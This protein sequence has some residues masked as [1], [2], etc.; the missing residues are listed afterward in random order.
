M[1]YFKS[2]GEKEKMF[3]WTDSGKETISDDETLIKNIGMAFEALRAGK[4]GIDWSQA[5]NSIGALL[6]QLERMAG[7]SRIQME[8]TRDGFGNIESLRIYSITPDNTQ[9]N[10]FF[11]EKAI[12]KKEGGDIELLYERMLEAGVPAVEK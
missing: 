3:K 7:E 10:L 5:L 12:F 1:S 8:T 9:E 6:S 4:E 2:E 11:S